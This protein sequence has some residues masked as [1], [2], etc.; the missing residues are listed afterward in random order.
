MEG[1]TGQISP[2]PSTGTCLLFARRATAA[3]I[4][5]AEAR[6]FPFEKKREPKVVMQ[7]D[8]SRQPADEATNDIGII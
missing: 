3:F 1:E 2:Q 6:C 4:S 8:K 7:K 5:S